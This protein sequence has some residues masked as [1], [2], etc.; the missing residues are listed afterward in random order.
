MTNKY[1]TKQWNFLEGCTPVGR[2]GGCRFCWAESMAHRFGKYWGIPKVNLD[3]LEHG[4]KNWRNPQIVFICNTSDLFHEAVNMEIISKAFEQM[5]RNSKHTYLILT[6]RPDKLVEFLSY[7]FAPDITPIIRSN[8]WLGATVENQL[9]ADIRI[10]KLLSCGKKWNYWLS[11]EPM[12]SE[13]NLRPEWLKQIKSVVIGMENAGKNHVLSQI[14]TLM[15][16]AGNFIIG[17]FHFLLNRD[18]KIGQTSYKSMS[19]KEI[20]LKGN[21]ILFQTLS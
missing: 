13:I 4:I 12:L 18:M 21:N 8:C 10:P 15:M 1:W 17:V 7:Y 9:Q 11:I 16:Y 3:I 20:C 14:F 5:W 2:E 6:K 19:I